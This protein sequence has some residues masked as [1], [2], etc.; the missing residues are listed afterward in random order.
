M[1][2]S[3]LNFATTC[4][5]SDVSSSTQVLC[6]SAVDS[7]YATSFISIVLVLLIGFSVLML[8]GKVY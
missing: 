6:Y 8:K 7:L 2:S 5:I 1:S 4:Y 3:S